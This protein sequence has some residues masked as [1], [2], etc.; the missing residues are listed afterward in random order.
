[1]IAVITAMP[2]SAVAWM[3][4]WRKRSSRPSPRRPRIVSLRPPSRIRRPKPAMIAS[5]TSPSR[6]LPPIH[7]TAKNAIPSPSENSGRNHLDLVIDMKHL[8]HGDAEEA[9]E[10][11]RERQRR[12]VLAG[13][14]RVDRL[15]RDAELRP[16]GALRELA[17]EAELPD[18]VPHRAH[19]FRSRF[20][21]Q[22][23]FTP[24]RRQASTGMER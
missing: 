24:V 12:R 7:W 22:V 16:E 9:G 6:G 23:R 20:S 19:S 1:M 2:A 13:L 5:E 8:L 14:D 10:G 3:S 17:L 21:C 11:E 15:P 4:I 18:V